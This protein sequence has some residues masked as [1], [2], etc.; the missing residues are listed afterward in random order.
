MLGALG[1]IRAPDGVRLALETVGCGPRHLLFAHGWI[2]S[3]RMWYE[4][5]ARLDPQRVTAHLLDFRGC[6]RS[7]RT[8]HGH[9]CDGYASD[10]R[11]ALDAM[12]GA[13]SLVAHSMG[14]KLAQLVAAAGHP[15]LEQLILVAPGT[16][17][18]AQPN[19]KH[20]SLTEAA[21]GDAER[22]ERFVRAAMVRPIPDEQLAR[23]VEDALDAQ[24]EHWFGWYDHGRT[25]DIRDRV[26]GLTTP[27]LV[28]A[29]E[30]DPL[31]P[32][33]RLRREVV[34]LL[35]AARMVT[36][37]GVGHNIPVEA[38]SEVAGAITVALSLA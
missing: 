33:D 4:V 38:A 18:G 6:G 10:L 26:I 28:L 30:R 2:S 27:T 17:R 9:T 5:V 15:R 11:A 31:A 8:P 14:G 12:P 37:R 13:V 22:I 35:T 7:D 32:P 34:G 3:R 29:G 1:S 25:A 16:G 36:I 24:Y 19:P 20:R 21:F 23:L